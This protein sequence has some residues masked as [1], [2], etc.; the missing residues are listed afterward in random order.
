MNLRNPLG[1]MRASAEMLVKNVSGE[2]EVA[3]ELAGYIS[4]EV[5]RTN[6]LITRFLEFSRPFPSAPWQRPT[7][8]T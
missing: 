2:I 1:T 3:R 5:D 6:A 7:S 8:W 4:T